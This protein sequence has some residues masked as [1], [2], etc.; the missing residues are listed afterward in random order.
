MVGCLLD[1]MLR[2]KGL[3][4]LRRGNVHDMHTGWSTLA[5]GSWSDNL[6]VKTSSARFNAV[7]IIEPSSDRTCDGTL[8]RVTHVTSRRLSNLVVTAPIKQRCAKHGKF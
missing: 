6:R 5:N 8:A 7:N 1:E 2:S 3:R 4:P